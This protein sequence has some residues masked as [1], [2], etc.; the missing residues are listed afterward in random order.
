[1][2]K[3]KLIIIVAIIALIV[4]GGAYAAWTSRATISVNAG[5]GEMDIE[6]TSMTIGDVSEYVTFGMDS[7]SVSEDKKSATISISNLYPGAEANATIIITNIG[8]IP[9]MLNNASMVREMAV[10]METNEDLSAKEAGNLIVKYT[11][12]ADTLSGQIRMSDSTSEVA[13]SLFENTGVVIEAGKTVRFDMLLLLDRE[14]SDETENALFRFQFVPVFVQSNMGSSG[15]ESFYEPQADGATATLA[16]ATEETSNS[17]ESSSDLM[18][19]TVLEGLTM[20]TNGMLGAWNGSEEYSGGANDIAIPSAIDDI[21]IM[22]IGQNTFRD[23]GLESVT[24]QEG[25][26]I[27][28]I[29]AR[30]FQGNQ[31]TEI[32]LPNSLT[33]I[34]TRAFYDNPISTV[35]IPD[36][37]T[38]IENNAFNKLIKITVG[39]NLTD[40]KSG[41]INGSNSFRDAYLSESGGAGTYI[42]DGTSWKKS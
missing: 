18:S 27:E 36:G 30:A 37:V 19:G 1:M 41:A 29:H 7:V 8:T 35:I 17:N 3:T 16:P 25:S 32:V 39:S 21:N 42:W 13:G 33:R 10:N 34:D 26:H 38:T 6:I 40:L 22:R 14:A 11:L 20:Q 23:K 28:R 31:L 24:F 4:V 15:S 12:T 5:S 9:I 2:R